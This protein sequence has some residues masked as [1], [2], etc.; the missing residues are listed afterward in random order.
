MNVLRSLAALFMCAAVA[1]GA[2]GAHALRNAL[3]IERLA[4]DMAIWEKAVLYNFI[5]AL[6]ALW[7]VSLGRDVLEPGIAKRLASIFLISTVIFCGSLYLLVLTNIRWLGM[8][9]PLGGVGFVIGWLYA[10]YR[11]LRSRV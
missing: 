7:T 9:T 4:Q 10:A 8:I 11:L 6:A 1:C 2:F 5:H 3:P